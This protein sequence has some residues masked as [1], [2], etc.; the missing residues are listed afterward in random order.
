LQRESGREGTERWQT[1]RG[2]ERDRAAW[3]DRYHSA[4]IV[5]PLQDELLCVCVCVCVC[6]CDYVISFLI[7]IPVQSLRSGSR[8][9]DRSLIAALSRFIR[10]N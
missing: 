1:R 8:P 3:D 2:R 4:A 5:Q 6:V 9:G 10:P 7:H